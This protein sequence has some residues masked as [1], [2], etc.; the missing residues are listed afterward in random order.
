MKAVTMNPMP[1]ASEAAREYL[2]HSLPEG[3]WRAASLAIGRNHAFIQQ[4]INRGKPTWLKE[5]DRGLLVSLYDFDADRLKQPP[6][7]AVALPEVQSK[8]SR[9]KPRIDAETIS[10]VYN[11]P[12]CRQILEAVMRIASNRNRESPRVLDCI[13]TLA[14]FLVVGH[15]VGI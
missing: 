10:R 5:W 2:R 6:K 12:I 4:Y 3:G 9:R 15:P 7:K 11:D 1:T 8:R 13:I 14:N